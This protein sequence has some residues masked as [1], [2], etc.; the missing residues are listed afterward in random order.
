MVGNCFQVSGRAEHSEENFGS[1]SSLHSQRWNLSLTWLCT[2]IHTANWQMVIRSFPNACRRLLWEAQSYHN[3]AL[4]TWSFL[5]WVIVRACTEA[6]MLLYF[7][8]YLSLV[9]GLDE[10]SGC[11]CLKTLHLVPGSYIWPSEAHY[12]KPLWQLMRVKHCPEMQDTRHPTSTTFFM[13]SC[14]K[15]DA[16]L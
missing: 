14:I 5:S 1:L 12:A 6:K 10:G 4:L 3:F 2:E 8:L 15:C 11:G 9:I 7:H 16:D 13:V